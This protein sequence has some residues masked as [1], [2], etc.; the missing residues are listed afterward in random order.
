MK[1]QTRASAVKK[2]R[3]DKEFFKRKKKSAVFD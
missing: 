2:E 1:A 3:R